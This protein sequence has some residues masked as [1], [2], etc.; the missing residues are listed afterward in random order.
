MHHQFVY[1]AF[2]DWFRRITDVNAF[3]D[4]KLWFHGEVGQD[5]LEVHRTNTVG[6]G[7]H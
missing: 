2:L 5:R 3:D 6:V 1:D 4:L 7:F